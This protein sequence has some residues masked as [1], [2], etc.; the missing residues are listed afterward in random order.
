M[1]DLIHTPRSPVG[2]R[3]ATPSVVRAAHGPA[4]A[5]AP[6]TAPRRPAPPRAYVTAGRA[7][8]ICR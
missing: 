6:Y 4:P 7:P 1:A 2:A 5:P 3:R 8:A